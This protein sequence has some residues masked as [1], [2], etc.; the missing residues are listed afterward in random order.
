MVEAALNQKF[1]QLMLNAANEVYDK[2]E[3]NDAKG[4]FKSFDKEK[5]FL[6]KYLEKDMYDILSATVTQAYQK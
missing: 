2:L 6:K 3:R 4:A 5:S 1:T